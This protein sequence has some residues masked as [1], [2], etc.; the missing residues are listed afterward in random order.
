LITIIGSIHWLP[1]IKGKIKGII[2]DKR[3]Q[4]VCIELDEGRYKQLISPGNLM[5]RL[6]RAAGYGDDM[7]GGVE[8]A[9]EVGA[10]LFL[11]DQDFA[12]TRDKLSRVL[13]EE[14][15]LRGLLRK[16][17]IITCMSPIALWHFL[18][19]LRRH[20]SKVYE[21]LI[22]EF[23]ANPK[24]YRDVYG[25]AYP[26][27]KKVILDEREEYMAQKISSLNERY[28]SIVVVTGAAHVPGLKVLLGNRDVNCV[29]IV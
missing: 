17:V 29:P 7:R 6:G 2:L 20:P 3:P 14:F 18:S 22:K 4:A 1:G 25:I 21:F 10:E 13:P 16:G 8:G 24:M 28:S 27:I 9:R 5:S 15:D 23:E 26:Y 11:I 12:E 19:C